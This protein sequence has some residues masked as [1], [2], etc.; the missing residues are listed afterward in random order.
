M[1]HVE[2]ADAVDD[3]ALVCQGQHR[4]DD[5]PVLA[6]VVDPRKNQN[7]NLLMGELGAWSQNLKELWE[8]GEQ[9]H[10][11]NSG[12]ARDAWNAGTL[13][14]MHQTETPNTERGA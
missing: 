13:H 8:Q 2:D 9:V 4:E 1:E 3:S 6:D 7:G 11:V 10:G 12:S 5:V 14:G